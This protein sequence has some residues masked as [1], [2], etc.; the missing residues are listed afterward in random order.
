LVF[1]RA[2]D[3]QRHDDPRTKKNDE[4]R[5]A[6]RYRY[7]Y[8]KCLYDTVLT[9]QAGRQAGRQAGYWYLRPVQ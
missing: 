3:F 1:Y 2:I 6:Y 9:G 7:R 4:D 5:L 8:D